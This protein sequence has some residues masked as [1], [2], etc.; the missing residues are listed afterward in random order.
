[1]RAA[2]VSKNLQA[3]V[4]AKRIGISRPTYSLYENNHRKKRDGRAMG[5]FASIMEVSLKWINEGGEA[6]AA[7]RKAEVPPRRGRN[8]QA[9]PITKGTKRLVTSGVDSDT[10]IE[11]LGIDQAKL[12]AMVAAGIMP[13]PKLIFDLTELQAAFSA[14][15]FR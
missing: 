2:R 9:G 12:D 7:L 11:A 13:K 6:P 15:R 10:V 14:V 8:P 4:V 1:M 3:D 5:K